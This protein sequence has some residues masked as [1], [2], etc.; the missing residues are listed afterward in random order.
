MHCNLSLGVVA[1]LLAGANAHGHVAKVIAG[2]KEYTGGIPHGA[3]SDAVGWAAG[4]QDNGFV[5]PDA[6][7][8]ADIICHKSAKPVSNAVTVAAGDV[9]TLKWDTWP[10]SH[11]G[12]VTEYL[13]PVSGDFA[14]INKQSL[15][16]IKVAQ[17][18]LKSGNNPGDWASDDLIRDGFSWK[19][20]VP[21]NLKAGN[22]VLRHEIIGLHSA[23]QAN[24]AQAYPQC[25]NLKVTGSGGQAISGGGDF[26]TFYTPTDP[27]ILFNLYQSFSSYPIPGPSVRS[28]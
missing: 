10:E 11:H 20:T 7:K 23:G 24:G 3:P 4:N 21:K 12:P 1:A 17:K 5:S 27:G 9:V 14:S 6:F 2:G 8:T 16:W 15:R 13:A 25:I 18:G 28:I 26:T 22:Y 19:F